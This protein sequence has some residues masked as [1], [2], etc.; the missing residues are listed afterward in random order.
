MLIRQFHKLSLW[1]NASHTSFIHFCKNEFDQIVKVYFVVVLT[2]KLVSFHKNKEQW[3]EKNANHSI[4]IYGNC[5]ISS[6]LLKKS[7]EQLIQLLEKQLS[8]IWAATTENFDFF[9]FLKKML[10]IQFPYMKIA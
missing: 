5:M 10:V 6:L 3:H 2:P 7:S 4:S 8:V 9:W 1:K